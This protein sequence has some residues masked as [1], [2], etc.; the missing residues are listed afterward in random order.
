MPK[1]TRQTLR[2]RF[3]EDSGWS[4]ARVHAL[5]PDASFRRYF[6]LERSGHSMML[7]DAPPEC[8]NA[9][10]FVRIT[11]HLQRLGVRAPAVHRADYGHGFVLLEDLGDDTFTRL[12]AAQED[13][14]GLYDQAIDLLTAI[15]NHP[16][17]TDLNIGKYDWAAFIREAELFTDWCLPALS[18]ESVADS[19]KSAYIEAWR[20]VFD[21]LPALEPTL[22]L[23]DYHVDNLM[24]VNNRCAVLDYQDALIGS[25]AY[26]VVSLLEDARRDLAP[27]L[28]AR[29]LERYLA[30]E[31]APDPQIFRHHYDVWGAQRHCKVAGIFMRLWLRDDKSAYLHHLPRVIRLLTAKLR[32]PPLRPIVEWFKINNIA[33]EYHQPKRSRLSPLLP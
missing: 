4:C 9:A 22:T 12:I 17:A 11:E 25:P 6:R 31:R 28:A 16:R 20:T 27:D 24:L 30:G 10:A 32:Q 33:L 29:S 1:M 26:D 3:L 7:M 8:E 5:K 21:A 23:R 13:E 15:H 18:D 19:V 14:A 2:N